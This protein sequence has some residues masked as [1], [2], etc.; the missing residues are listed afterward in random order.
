MH[1]PLPFECSFV[2][3]EEVRFDFF[4]VLLFLAALLRLQVA[5]ISILI[6]AKSPAAVLPRIHKNKHCRA[7]YGRKECRRKIVK[8]NN[9]RI[10]AYKLKIYGTLV[11]RQNPRQRRQKLVNGLAS[12][13]NVQVV[14]LE[15]SS[16]EFH[17]D[18]VLS[19]Y[20]IIFNS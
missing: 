11:R 12:A 4:L 16:V 18:F 5:S 9:K 8:I 15:S 20:S 6:G 10:I 1:V 2:E 13:P 14:K 19:F 7:N 17:R 3:R